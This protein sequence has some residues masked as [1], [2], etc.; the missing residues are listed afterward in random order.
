MIVGLLVLVGFLA[1]GDALSSL[2]PLHLPGNVL[3]MVLLALSLRL[4]LLRVEP[5]RPAA[6]LLT[7]HMALFF[8]PPGVAV[9][10]HLD[11]LSRAF[12]PIVVSSAVSTMAVMLVVGRVAQRSQRS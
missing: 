6:E 11:T 5:L 12:V 1:L 2:S 10:L 3:G 8:V 9:M 4:R 7:R